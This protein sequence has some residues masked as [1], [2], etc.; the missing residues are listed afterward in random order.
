MKRYSSLISACVLSMG[1][2]APASAAQPA[3]LGPNLLVQSRSAPA[4]CMDASLD[5]NEEGHEVYVFRCHGHYNQ[6]WTLTDGAD[7]SSAVVAFDGRCV[8]IRGRKV[9]DNTPVQLW[10][11]HYGANQQFEVTSLGQIREK[12]SGKCL[13]IGKA[14][15]DRR[16]VYIDDCDGNPTQLWIVKRTENRA[17][18]QDPE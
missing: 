11:C 7:G 13:T 1:I 17:A 6:R 12:Q 9:N 10:R 3:Q 16:P 8:D 5:R 15:A 14:T 2:A 4:Y 18:R